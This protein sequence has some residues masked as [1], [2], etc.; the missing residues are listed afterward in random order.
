MQLTLPNTAGFKP[1]SVLYLMTLNPVTGGHDVVGQM[2]V[3]ADGETM[4]S[5]GPIT[6]SGTTGTSAGPPPASRR[7]PAGGSDPAVARA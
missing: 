2:V 4:T 6:L 5:T 3:S 7:T 1:G